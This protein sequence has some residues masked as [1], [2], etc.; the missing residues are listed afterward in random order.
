MAKKKG[1]SKKKS[2]KS[3]AKSNVMRS[4]GVERVL[5]E[6]FISLQ[7]VLSDLALKLDSLTNKVTELV[8]IFESSAKSLAE[9]DFN[10]EKGNKDSD[11][12]MQKMDN[13]LE[14]NKIIAKGLTLM[15]ESINPSSEEEEQMTPPTQQRQPMMPPP[16]QMPQERYQKSIASNFKPIPSEHNA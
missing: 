3:H 11:K 8:A 4:A 10:L 12:I 16:R 13:L 6:N 9:R 2:V 14:Q 7:N 1:G 15:H 5:F